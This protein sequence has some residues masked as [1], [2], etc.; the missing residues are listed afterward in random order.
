MADALSFRDK[1]KTIAAPRSKTWHKTERVYKRDE[2]DGVV[3]GFEDKH[4][5]G[6][7]DATVSPRPVS[8]RLHVED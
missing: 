6:S 7:Q 4:W 1:I 3:R 2:R 8:R 5:D